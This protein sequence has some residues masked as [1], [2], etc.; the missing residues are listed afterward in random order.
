MRLCERVARTCQICQAVK[1]YKGPKCGTMD[2]CPIPSD[3][4]SS[5]CMDFLDLP[6]CQGPDGAEYDYVLVVVCRL[7]GYVLAFPCL[8]AGLTAERLAR[9]Y[10]EKFVALI[11]L[12]HEIM[13]DNDHLI[14]SKFFTTLCQCAGISQLTSILYR[15]R[16]NGR[17]EAAVRH[18]VEILRRS[19]AMA[20]ENWVVTLPWA[21]FTLNDLPGVL[22]RHSPYKIVFG[23]NAIALGDLEPLRSLPQVSPGGE[24]WFE[25]LFAMR[26]E[27]QRQVT[28]IHE[29]LHRQYMEKMK[30]VEYHPGDR[31][32]VRNL[33]S[34]V[35][36]LNPLYTGPCEIVARKPG[37]GR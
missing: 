22:G 5:L 35:N 14:T 19:L 24:K 28:N 21:L 11:G 3:I 9:L 6:K 27:V 30:T 26:K 25:D 34:E 1:P 20:K 4:F 29:K 33:D 7:S 16:G 17:A 8:K 37:T 36:K 23:R 10:M 18:V 2:F 12:P 13:S 15:P 31:V 32:W